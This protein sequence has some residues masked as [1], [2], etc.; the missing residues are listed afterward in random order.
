MFHTERAWPVKCGASR[1][2]E[3]QPLALAAGAANITQPTVAEFVQFLRGQIV[4]EYLPAYAPELNPVEYLWGHWKHHELPNVCPHD[5]WQ[6]TGG[7]RRT[8]VPTAPPSAFDNRLL[9]AGFFI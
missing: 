4:L 6:L 7:A 9:E 2:H 3:L 5:L 1:W 8:L